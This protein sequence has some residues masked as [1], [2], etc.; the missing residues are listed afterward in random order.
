[1]NKVKF[2]YIHIWM[3][4]LLLLL[5]PCII[6]MFICSILKYCIDL[7]YR[8]HTESKFYHL[9]FVPWP[10]KDIL[11]VQIRRGINA[12]CVCFCFLTSIWLLRL[13]DTCFPNNKTWSMTWTTLTNQLIYLSRL[14]HEIYH[15]WSMVYIPVICIT[16]STLYCSLSEFVMN[17]NLWKTWSMTWTTLTNQ[18]IYLSRRS[19]NILNVLVLRCYI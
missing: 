17:I 6:G 15:A 9:H 14:I 19:F 5:F 2:V 12:N 11:L 1:M 4:Q 8:N 16:S 18:L 3:H 10:L 13:Y 7:K